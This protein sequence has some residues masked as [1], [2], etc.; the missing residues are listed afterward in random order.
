M[1]FKKLMAGV[2]SGA[3]ILSVTAFPSYA[4]DEITSGDFQAETAENVVSLYA[5]NEAW[6]DEADTSWYLETESQYTISTAQQLAGLAKLVNDGTS[7]QKKEI[8]LGN[9]IDLAGKEWTP[10]GVNEKGKYF[11]GNFNGNGNT[12]FNLT[13]TNGGEYTG[14]FGFTSNGASISDLTLDTVYIRAVGN[15]VGALGGNLFTGARKNIK[16]LNADIEAQGRYV[17]G[18]AGHSYGT[19]ENC[20]F[21]GKVRT[22]SGYNLHD[23]VGGIVGSGGVDFDKCIVRGEVSGWLWVGGICGNMQDG[24]GKLTNCY[25]EGKIKA[26]GSW[27][28]ISAGGL[29]GTPLIEWTKDISNNYCNAECYLNDKLIDTPIIGAFNG[30]IDDNS[31][32]I[33]KN[34]SWN[35]AIYNTDTIVVKGTD[36]NE[37]FNTGRNNTLVGDV[38]D[39]Q[40]LSETDLENNNVKII[41]GSNI[42]SIDYSA[43]EKLITVESHDGTTDVF[44]INDNGS[45]VKAGAD[46]ITVV[47]KETSEANVY[48][49]ALQ[50][51]GEKAINRLNS[52]DISFANNSQLIAGVPGAID[53][54]IEGNSA[55][56]ITVNNVVNDRY[57]FHFNGKDNVSDTAKELVIGTV[58]F[59]GYGVINF[60]I[61][62]SETNAVHATKTADSIVETYTTADGNLIIDYVNAADGTNDSAI[63]N[64]T[65]SVPTNKLTV[66]IAMNNKVNDNAKDYQKMKVAIAG[67]TYSEEIE[68]GTDG[69]A[70]TNDA[71]VIERDLAENTPYTVTVSGE[72]YRTAR[73][74][75]TMNADK[76]LNFWNNV[77]DK[78]VEVEEGKEASA[79]EVTFL[80]GDIVKD[81]TINIYDLS[82]VVSYFGTINNVDAESEYAKYDLN[83]DGKIDSKDVAYVLVS[84][85]K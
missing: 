5:A 1:N 10:I 34:N 70:L 26:T 55:N 6:I 28:G 44:E 74:T 71:Y 14:L 42:S 66:N 35:K 59:T 20:V 49:I 46:K 32:D 56:N 52:M 78:A 11:T 58:T 63:D 15:R 68:L 83:R 47:F 43:S 77:K 29:V 62:N 40:Y 25:V 65:L 30:S 37:S 76:V 19:Y 18:I 81:G 4:A 82:A 61:D 12:I 53:Y 36:N 3:V 17:G 64:V 13:I 22:K 67:G 8:A 27:A 23:Q 31:A 84:W 16:V 54:T 48:E 9:D 2:L 79:K 60:A 24:N 21:E 38:S 51:A 75:V 33:I 69:V 57:E 72:G 73:Y 7:F 41:G 85:G 45:I 50:A 39:I 80:A